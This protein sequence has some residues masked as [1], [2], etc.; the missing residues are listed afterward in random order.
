M[1]GLELVPFAGI[2]CGVGLRVSLIRT[3]TGGKRYWAKED[4]QRT[5]LWWTRDKDCPVLASNIS[6]GPGDEKDAKKRVWHCR[7]SWYIVR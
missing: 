6:C 3:G 7:A 5:L 1:G 4:Q 2:G